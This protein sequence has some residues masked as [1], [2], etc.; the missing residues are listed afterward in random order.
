MNI[1]V[2]I[3]WHIFKLSWV[4]TWNCYWWTIWNS[5]FLR[6]CFSKKLHNL[7]S[8]Q[9]CR[10]VPIF[11]QQDWHLL[12]FIFLTNPLLGVKWYLIMGFKKLIWWL[13]LSCGM[14][15]PV[16][17]M[18]HLVL[19]PGIEPWPPA[20]GVRSLSHWTT[21]KWFFKSKFSF[22]WS[23]VV[24]KCWVFD[25]QQSESALHLAVSPLFWIS[26][27]FIIMVLSCIS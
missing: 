13:G 5:N 1:H 15:T 16:C 17:I 8:Y 19:W 21:G 12:L 26:F 7:N 22:Y 18:Q 11:P 2:H 23:T 25:I 6:N 27:P 10:R 14:Q 3:F 9:H 20:L 24:L 4:Y